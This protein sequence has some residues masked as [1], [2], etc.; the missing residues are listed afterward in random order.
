MVMNLKDFINIRD[1]MILNT[2]GTKE[3]Q[4]GHEE[5]TLRKKILTQRTQRKNTK[6]TKKEH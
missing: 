4:E 5:G 6:A 3:E 1:K 2:K